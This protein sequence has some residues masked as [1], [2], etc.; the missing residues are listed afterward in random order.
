MRGAKAGY[1]RLFNKWMCRSMGVSVPDFSGDVDDLLR[2]PAKRLPEGKFIE[3]TV[4]PTV[5]AY[6]EL[7]DRSGKGLQS[8]LR[9]V[10]DH[11]YTLSYADLPLAPVRA[12]H[13]FRLADHLPS[14]RM[15]HS[16]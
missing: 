4:A 12:G 5:D 2:L 13:G 16:S 10:I 6:G 3:I 1:R 9:P 8:K 11:R 14:F 7:V 15:D